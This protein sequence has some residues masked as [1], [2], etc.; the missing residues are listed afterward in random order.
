MAKRKVETQPFFAAL[1]ELTASA[2][3]FRNASLM[4][5][6][7]VTAALE[8][9]AVDERLKERVKAACDRWHESAFKPTEQ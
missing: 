6:Q 3:E 8:V 7:T 2:D 5:Y 9:G 4:L 1:N